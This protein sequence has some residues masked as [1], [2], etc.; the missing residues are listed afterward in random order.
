MYEER[1]TAGV[2]LLDAHFRA[3]PRPDGFDWRSIVDPDTLDLMDSCRCV[4]GQVFGIYAEGLTVLGLIDPEDWDNPEAW[5][6]G[7]EEAPPESSDY[8]F[9]T[10]DHGD[11]FRLTTEWR[12]VL[13]GPVRGR[14]G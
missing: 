13:S 6:E 7:A 5:P 4:L 11:Y 3:N 9:A 1:I 10:P 12:D 2:A 8:G 14:L